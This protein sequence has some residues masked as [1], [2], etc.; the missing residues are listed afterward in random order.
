M[1]WL[2]RTV[3]LAALLILTFFAYQWWQPEKIRVALDAPVVT[4]MIFNPSEMDA[5]ELYFEENPHSR[6]EL[7]PL[8]YDLDPDNS[9]LGFKAQMS[10]GT[11]FLSRHRPPR[12]SQ[13][14][15]TYFKHPTFY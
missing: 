9:P 12:R 15:F 13:R 1:Y 8:Y 2:L 3:V 6:I 4:R 11:A 14:A 7:I 5:A 10:A